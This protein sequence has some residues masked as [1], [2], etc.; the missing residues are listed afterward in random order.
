MAFWAWYSETKIGLKDSSNIEKYV[1]LCNAHL[2]L[3]NDIRYVNMILTS[4]PDPG[5][6]QAISELTGEMDAHRQ[7]ATEIADRGSELG[8]AG[9]QPEDQNISKPCLEIPGYDFLYFRD[10]VL[11]VVTRNKVPQKAFINATALRKW[12]RIQ[13]KWRRWRP[14]RNRWLQTLRN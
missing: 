1:T 12:K 14:R 7:E 8:Q 4:V 9:G 13:K 11:P 6:A 3:D 5:T 10:D 2:V